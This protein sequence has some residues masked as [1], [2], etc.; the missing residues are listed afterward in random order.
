[1]RRQKPNTYTAEFKASAVKL[2]NE[3]DKSVAQVALDLG[4]NMNTVLGFE[5]E[6]E[7]KRFLQD[8]Q[9]LFTMAVYYRSLGNSRLNA[10]RPNSAA[11]TFTSAR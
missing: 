3:S 6:Q 8:M 4:I 7:A 9:E 5:Y 11:L 1:M 10:V 2:E